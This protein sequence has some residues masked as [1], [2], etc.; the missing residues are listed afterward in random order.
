M[1]YFP[2]MNIE[3]EVQPADIWTRLFPY[4]KDVAMKIAQIT[5][6]S[7]EYFL[8]V[9]QLML[10]FDFDPVVEY[11]LSTLENFGVLR[12]TTYVQELEARYAQLT[13]EIE[14]F[15][16]TIEPQPTVSKITLSKQLEE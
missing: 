5:G 2:N 11:G 7:W 16:H 15:L 14:Q 6:S 1:I 8:S 13:S 4:Q 10:L 12:K 9:E 3:D